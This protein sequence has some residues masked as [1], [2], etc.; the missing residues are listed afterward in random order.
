M[1]TYTEE[2]LRKL[3]SLIDEA[4]RPYTKENYQADSII[5]EFIS[6]GFQEKIEE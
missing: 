3:A 2:D 5:E 1:K 6:F 4:Y